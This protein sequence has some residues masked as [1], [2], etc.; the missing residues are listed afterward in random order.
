MQRTS[1]GI[2]DL[3]ALIV[4]M[5]MIAFNPFYLDPRLMEI[6]EMGWR[7]YSSHFLLQLNRLYPVTRRE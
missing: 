2:Q 6:M 4:M 7:S 5:C 3:R 1:P